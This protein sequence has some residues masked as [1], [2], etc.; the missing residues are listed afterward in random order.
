MRRLAV[1]SLLLAA[2]LALAGWT[3]ADLK[4]A[5]TQVELREEVLF[6]DRAAAEGLRVLTHAELRNSTA[7]WDTVVSFMEDGPEVS[8]G[9]HW[10]VNDGASYRV[11]LGDSFSM[12]FL[13][14]VY[15]TYSLGGGPDY[16]AGGAVY[17]SGGYRAATNHIRDVM[18]RTENGQ[19]R[20]EVVALGTTTTPASG[21]WR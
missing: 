1:F 20:R 9:F 11:L 6:G 5:A 10:G 17:T 4:S 3:A 13:Q 12:D 7:G 18:S 19:M 21:I 8:A 2:A 14:T 15:N 16:Q